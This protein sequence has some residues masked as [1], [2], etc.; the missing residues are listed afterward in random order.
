MKLVAD[1]ITIHDYIR[2]GTR[3]LFEFQLPEKV[4]DD[5]K[6]LFT[7]TSGQDDSGEGERGSQVAEIWLIRNQK[8]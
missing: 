3:P 1:G 7:W 6:V 8:R 2:M 4:T 5:G